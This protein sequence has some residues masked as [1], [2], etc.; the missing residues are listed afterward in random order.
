MKNT[1]EEGLP[2]GKKL[3]DFQINGLVKPSHV[4][5]YVVPELTIFDQVKIIQQQGSY[6]LAHLVSDDKIYFAFLML[7]SD[8]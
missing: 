3:E 1:V 8:F 7:K 6:Y 5:R 4:Q 2:K